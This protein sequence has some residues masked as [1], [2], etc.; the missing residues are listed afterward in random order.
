MGWRQGTYGRGAHVPSLRGLPTLHE[1]EEDIA[2]DGQRRPQHQHGEEEGADGV[3]ILVLGLGGVVAG[4]TPPRAA[5]SPLAFSPISPH[6]WTS[7]CPPCLPPPPDLKE[8]DVGCYEDADT[9]QQIPHHVDE[10]GTDAGVGLF[11]GVGLL[12]SP[13]VAV[14]MPSLVQSRPHP[15]GRAAVISPATHLLPR[16]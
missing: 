13:S 10:G 16:G 11:V 5:K 12:M 8:D 4:E 2:E 14:P 1:D 6:G 3:H 9:L 15:A 7:L